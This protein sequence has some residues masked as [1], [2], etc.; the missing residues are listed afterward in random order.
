MRGARPGDARP[1]ARAREGVMGLFYN[2][3]RLVGTNLRKAGWV[4]R[5]LAGTEAEA[6]QAEAAVGRDLAADFLREA[7]PDEDPAVGS[8]LAD[9]SARLAGGLRQRRAFSVRAVRASEVN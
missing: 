7:E 4:A 5:S 9:L 6:L 3:G 1:P 2:L 8:L